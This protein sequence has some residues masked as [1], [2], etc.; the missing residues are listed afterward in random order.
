MRRLKHYRE[1]FPLAD[2]SHRREQNAV[3]N[4]YAEL[5][6]QLPCL[7]FIQRDI[8]RVIAGNHCL[9][10]QGII[11]IQ[12]P[13]AEKRRLSGRNDQRVVAFLI[14]RPQPCMEVANF[15]LRRL[16]QFARDIT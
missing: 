10:A 12:L 1:L 13:K 3:W 15:F 14:L 6:R 16:L 4:R 8:K 7:F 9:A 5:T 2:F 11:L